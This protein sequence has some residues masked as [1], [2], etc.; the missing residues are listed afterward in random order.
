MHHE[1]C[2]IA[3]VRFQ[4]A[5]ICTMPSLFVKGESD[6]AGGISRGLNRDG[7]RSA[8]TPYRPAT[9]LTNL[10]RGNVQTQ[11]PSELPDRGTHELAGQGELFLEDMTFDD[12]FDANQ[13]DKNGLTPLMWAASY[14]QLATAKRLLEL[15]ASVNTVGD[16]GET[17]LI[18]A[19][20]A[21]HAPV[22]REL[23]RHGVY[24]N[25]RDQDG[26]TALMYS[27]YNNHAVCATEL[28]NAGADMLLLNECGENVFEIATQRRAKHAQAALERHML[29]LM[30]LDRLR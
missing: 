28:L 9:V 16:N 3:T 4:R 11:T 18:L 2:F 14:G 24:M 1:H 22:V 27:V 7:N 30:D 26:N 13:T 5:L 25:Y 6:E 17:A 10:Q 15:G 19:A 12:D 20:S 21:G 29:S 8:F 23:I